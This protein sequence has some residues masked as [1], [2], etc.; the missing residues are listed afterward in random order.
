MKGIDS[1]KEK[2]KHKDIIVEEEE[3]QNES[4]HDQ[5]NFS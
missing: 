5:S 1:E 4:S 2:W 3:C